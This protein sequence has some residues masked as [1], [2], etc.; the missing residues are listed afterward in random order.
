VL[1]WLD[2]KDA[3][4]VMYINFGSCAYTNHLQLM[5]IGSA[6]EE[7]NIPFI[8]VIKKI[9]LKPVVKE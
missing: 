3:T 2:G 1:T 4:S 6:L 9:E 8:W 7:S 5:E